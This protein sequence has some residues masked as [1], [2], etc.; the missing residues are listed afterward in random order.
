MLAALM[1]LDSAGNTV[2]QAAK[3][4]CKKQHFDAIE[5]SAKKYQFCPN[6]MQK[7]GGCDRGNTCSHS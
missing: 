5:K 7:D 6:F 1:S 3:D 2:R 4:E